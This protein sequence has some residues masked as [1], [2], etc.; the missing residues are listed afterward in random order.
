MV[1]FQDAVAV[2]GTSQLD[3]EGAPRL[4]EPIDTRIALMRKAIHRYTLL[5]LLAFPTPPCRR[6]VRAAYNVER[7]CTKLPPTSRRSCLCFLDVKR[8]VAHDPRWLDCYSVFSC[9]QMKL[10]ACA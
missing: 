9:D 6:H 3:K 10:Q 4:H 5:T 8:L 1:T 2:D 7:E